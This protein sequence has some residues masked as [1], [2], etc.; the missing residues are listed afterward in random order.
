MLENLRTMAR[1]L[2]L[3][4]ERFEWSLQGLGMLRLHIE[5]SNSRLHI[6]DR[7]FAYPGASPIHDHQ[8]WAL[9]STV[10]SGRLTN[11]RFVERE[12]GEAYW[13]QLIKAGYGY[14]VKEGPLP[15]CLARLAP[16][17]YEVG[18][19]YSQRPEE[20]HETVPLDG[21][22]TLMRKT[23]TADPEAARVFWPV[24]EE[25]GTAEPRAA[26]AQEVLDITRYALSIFDVPRDGPG[27]EDGPWAEGFD[28]RSRT[29]N[30]SIWRDAT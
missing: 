12:D 8:Q 26:T 21:T 5:G 28:K 27:E 25:W 14:F 11:Y 20:I 4:A 16:E 19:T 9:H 3:N 2:L 22:V 23:P 18:D 29:M 17:H 6:W 7:R 13:Y 10:L 30:D 1:F 15:I 24:G